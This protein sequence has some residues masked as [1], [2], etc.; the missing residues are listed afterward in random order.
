[1]AWSRAGVEPSLDEG[2]ADAIGRLMM[3]RARLPAEDV[4]AAS[5]LLRRG[6]R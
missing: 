6:D 4:R 2:R 3:R 5:A 1:V